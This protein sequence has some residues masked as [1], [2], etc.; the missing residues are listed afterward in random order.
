MMNNSKFCKFVMR[1]FPV[2]DFYAPEIPE[3]EQNVD[4]ANSSL[5]MVLASRIVTN[6]FRD[7]IYCR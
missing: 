2:P 6:G 1:F 7:Y 5:R 3:P 4:E